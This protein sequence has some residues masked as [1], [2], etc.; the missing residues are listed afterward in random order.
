MGNSSME[1]FLK[2]TLSI[3]LISFALT[4]EVTNKYYSYGSSIYAG[5]SSCTFNNVLQSETDRES[6]TMEACLVTCNNV[7]DC[8]SFWVNFGA[9]YMLNKTICSDV[10]N[11]R[12][13]AADV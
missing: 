10:N 7:Q 11:K 13:A 3:L 8:G 12:V 1:M 9:C 2:L 6:N 4:V 5:D